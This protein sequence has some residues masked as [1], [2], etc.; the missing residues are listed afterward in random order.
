M[1]IESIKDLIRYLRVDNNCHIRKRLGLMGVMSSDLIPILINS[2]N[3]IIQLNEQDEEEEGII[4][5]EDEQKRKKKRIKKKRKQKSQAYNKE[6][7]LYETVA[8]LVVNLTQPAMLCFSQEASEENSCKKLKLDLQEI[9]FTYKKVV[10][11][12]SPNSN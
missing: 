3:N 10:F 12:L 6:R 7:I 1:P 11:A 5:E 8:R 4:N 2:G 9:L